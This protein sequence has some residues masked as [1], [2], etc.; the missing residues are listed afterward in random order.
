MRYFINVA[1]QEILVISLTDF[2][3]AASWR[4]N[5]V[6]HFLYTVNQKSVPA[7]RRVSSTDFVFQ[8]DSGQCTGKPGRARA[9][10][11]L[12]RQEMPNIFAPNLWPPN[13]LISVLWI[14]RSGLSRPHSIILASYKLGCKPGRRLRESVTSRSKACRKQVASQLQTC[15]K[16]A[17]NLL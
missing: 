7:I 17:S 3:D 13:S 2:L 9:T 15:C 5:D 16:L 10:V 11:E 8:Q 6:I 1:K 12:L 14:T 4:H